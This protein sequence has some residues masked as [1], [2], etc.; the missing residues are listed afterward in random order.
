MPIANEAPFLVTLGFD[1]ATFDRLDR[2]RARYFPADRNLVPA[3]LS[4]FH[5]LPGGEGPAIDEA[6]AE[7]ARASGPIPLAF[8]HPKRTGRG[9]MVEV[10]ASGLAAIRSAI[11]RRF[12]AALTDQD[13][14]P[15]R[16]H[17]MLM[18]KADRAEVD[19]AYAEIRATWAPWSGLGDRII[20]W[21]Y[22]GGPWEEVE[23]YELT[24]DVAPATSDLP[25]SPTEGR[26]A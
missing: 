21:R 4:L 10:G 11:A 18:N 17:V 22:L 5:H 14:Q 6:L 2:L 26:G 20:L 3:H 1:P 24:G 19:S 25:S 16:P 13:R 8:A 7:V 9:M 23:S 15:F 12:A